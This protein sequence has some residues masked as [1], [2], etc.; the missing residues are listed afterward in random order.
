MNNNNG[1]VRCYK[2][3]G[4]S[5]RAIK[6]HAF[7]RS[8]MNTRSSRN[9]CAKR[10]TKKPKTVISRKR[11][12]PKRSSSLNKDNFK[13]ILRNKK[14]SSLLKLVNIKH[15]SMKN[16]VKKTRL[17]LHLYLLIKHKYVI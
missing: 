11:K 7:K 15:T 6:K 2:K 12:S 4:T 9:E 3:K 1:K 14:K 8:T 17:T 16:R 13:R 10:I 5:T